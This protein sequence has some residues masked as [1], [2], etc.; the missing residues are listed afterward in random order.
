MTDARNAAARLLKDSPQFQAASPD[1][2]QAMMDHWSNYFYR[3]GQAPAPGTDLHQTP[4]AP[5]ADDKPGLGTRIWNFFAGGSQP[6][7]PPA[8]AQQ[9]GIPIPRTPDGKIDRSQLK[10]GTLYDMPGVG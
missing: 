4:D 10:S 2:Q 1:D 8:P 7:Q 3:G 5:A 9:K 6:A